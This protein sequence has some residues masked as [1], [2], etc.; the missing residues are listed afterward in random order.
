[1]VI[2]VS[3]MSD[4]TINIDNNP[5][6]ILHGRKPEDVYVA[7][8]P[9]PDND[10]VLT[11]LQVWRT[12]EQ[13]LK[14]SCEIN[15]GQPLDAYVDFF[16]PKILG[17]RKDRTAIDALVAALKTRIQ[18]LSET[19]AVKSMKAL[20]N[21]IIPQ[22]QLHY[23]ALK[24]D[25]LDEVL[26]SEPITLLEM[27]ASYYI[28]KGNHKI[29]ACAKRGRTLIPCQVFHLSQF[30]PAEQKEIAQRV[31]LEHTDFVRSAKRYGGEGRTP[32]FIQVFKNQVTW[33]IK[34]FLIS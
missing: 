16:G 5:F 4:A 28:I 18:P 23:F 30:L 10:L 34:N 31:K 27:E 33:D 15:G 6:N 7:A 12:Y 14:Y 24:D 22:R 21:K 32:D 8:Y 3:G 11:P 13:F 29:T 19:V 20:Q 25:V 2:G 26:A 1:M 17:T 9:V